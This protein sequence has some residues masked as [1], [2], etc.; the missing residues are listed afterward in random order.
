MDDQIPNEADI[1]SD[2]ESAEEDEDDDD[3]DGKMHLVISFLH[4]SLQNKP[5]S[6]KNAESEAVIWIKQE[7]KMAIF[8]IIDHN[9]SR[10]RE[11]SYSFEIFEIR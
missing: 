8:I 2:E 5:I 11:V 6:E 9:N 1:L 10:I 3:E 7:E 4:F